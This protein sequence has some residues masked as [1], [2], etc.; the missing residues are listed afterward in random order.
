MYFEREVIVFL[1]PQ[2]YLGFHKPYFLFFFFLGLDIC[3]SE[4][5]ESNEIAAPHDK[6]DIEEL[7]VR[8]LS[9]LL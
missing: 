7:K 5:L 2:E 3:S 9:L 6:R 4:T 8:L 1:C